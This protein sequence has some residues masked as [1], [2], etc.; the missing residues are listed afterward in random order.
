[1]GNRGGITVEAKALMISHPPPAPP[2]KGG[3]LKALRG[4]EAVSEDKADTPC[5]RIVVASEGPFSP[6]FLVGAE[7]G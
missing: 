5:V 3:G 4:A 7:W 2:I 1:M 6:G